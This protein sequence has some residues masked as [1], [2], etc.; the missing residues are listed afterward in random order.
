MGGD[1]RPGSTGSDSNQPGIDV[2]TNSLTR[3]PSPLTTGLT[4]GVSSGRVRLRFPVLETFAYQYGWAFGRGRSLDDAER[5]LAR[6][7]FANSLDLDAVRIVSTTLAAAPTT[8]GDYIRTAGPMSNATLIHELTHVW[9]FQ[10]GGRR[11]HLGLALRTGWRLGLD[12]IAQRRL[13]PH[14]RR[15]GR[16]AIQRIHRRTA[17]DDRRNVLFRPCD[18]GRCDL[19]GADRR[20]APATAGARGHTPA[21]DLR[22]R[23]VRP[24]ERSPAQP[25]RRS[26]PAADHAAVPNRFL[27]SDRRADRWRLSIA[28]G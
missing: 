21:V 22:G 24:E 5:R 19:S 4:S 13:R 12:R 2:G 7:V 8:L 11:L 27:R 14:R 18:A 26:E 15:P 23:V 28:G 3:M 10:H 9:Q 16:K 17:G 20:G 25:A 6:E 1:G